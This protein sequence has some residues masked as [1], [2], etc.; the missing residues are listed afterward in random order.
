MATVKLGGL[1]QF[2]A[3]RRT[4]SKMVLR[5]RLELDSISAGRKCNHFQ[6]YGERIKKQR[7]APRILCF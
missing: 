4:C 6:T 7:F 1:D 2:E 5:S 3:P